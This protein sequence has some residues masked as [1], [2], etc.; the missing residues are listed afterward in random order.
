[1]AD[2][3][4]L[5][6]KRIGWTEFHSNGIDILHLQTSYTEKSLCAVCL[7]CKQLC[8]QA[9]E[10]IALLSLFLTHI[11]KYFSLYVYTGFAA[12]FVWRFGL[13]AGVDW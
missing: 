8:T 9:L 2:F 10:N 3:Y 7:M 4:T 1:M 6:C 12:I 13:G 11:Y 5:P